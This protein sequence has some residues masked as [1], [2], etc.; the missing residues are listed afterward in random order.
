MNTENIKDELFDIKYQIKNLRDKS[1]EL[2]EELTTLHLQ[3]ENLIY[4]ELPKLSEL[5]Q[6][7]STEIQDSMDG[8]SDYSWS[9]G[10]LTSNSLLVEPINYTEKPW[11]EYSEK[12]PY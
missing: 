9:I 7:P 1:D 6:L 11:P 3:I 12:A 4:D 10:P 5:Q 8:D 2:T